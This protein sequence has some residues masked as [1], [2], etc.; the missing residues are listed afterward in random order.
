MWRGCRGLEVCSACD[1]A[2]GSMERGIS[3][4]WS[5]A[6]RISVRAS[7]VEVESLAGSWGAVWVWW[8]GQRYLHQPTQKLTAGSLSLFIFVM[9]MQQLLLG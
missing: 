1:C 5:P 9:E 4:G 7:S 3:E 2:D 6:S 8:N